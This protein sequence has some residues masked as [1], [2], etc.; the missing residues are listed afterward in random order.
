MKVA[1]LTAPRECTLI[2]KP[3]PRRR[4]RYA[5]VRVQ[6][7]PM[8]NEHHAYASW[9]FRDRNRPDSLGHEAAGEVVEAGP[10]SPF[11]AGDRVVALSGYPCGRCRLC[12]SGCYAHCPSPVDPLAA[13]G[14]ESGECCFAQ[15]LLKADWLLLPIPDHLSYEQA[16]MACCGL[17][18]TFTAMQTMGVGPGDSVLITG[19]GPVG[20]GG[21][22]NAV[23]RGARVIGAARHPY[24]TRL[25]L[26]LGAEAVV[27]PRDDGARATILEL[28]AGEGVT[29]G[30]EC[31]AASMYQR[32]ALDVLGRRGRMTFLGESG[33]LAVDVDGDVIQKGVT[34]SGSLD[35]YL[36]HAPAMMELIGRATTQI[37]RFITHRLPLAQIQEAWE[38][39]LT[40]DCGKIVLYP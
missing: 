3:L 35:L 12:A 4:G 25:A 36:Q 22:I 14:S 1:A 28:T 38:T 8:C 33:E 34:I 37:D 19:L 31:S 40:G 27:D 10:G 11:R 2:D 16:S 24:R 17:G 9:D 32:L 29:C 21:V 39:Q 6:V 7:A 23:L 5:I 15:Y 18:A 30:I 13:C 20:L 26:E